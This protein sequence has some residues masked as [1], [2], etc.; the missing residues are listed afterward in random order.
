MAGKQK[1]PHIEIVA[2]WISNQDNGVKIGKKRFADV[3]G[4]SE[5]TVRRALKQAEIAGLV[6]PG[7]IKD[8]PVQLKGKGYNSND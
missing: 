8:T 3:L 7:T 6:P 2:I 1:F 5:R 4:V